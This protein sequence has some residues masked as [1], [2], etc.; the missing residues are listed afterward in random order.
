MKREEKRMERVGRKAAGD[1]GFVSCQRISLADGARANAIPNAAGDE[2]GHGA[3]KLEGV[4][5][6]YIF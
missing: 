6:R 5:H 4:I 1:F 3:I 2:G